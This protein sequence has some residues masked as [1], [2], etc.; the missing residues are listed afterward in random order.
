[1]ANLS[2]EERAR[3][4]DI[5]HNIQAASAS[6]ANVDPQKVPNIEEIE[7]CL[8][9]ADKTLRAVLQVSKQSKQ[10]GEQ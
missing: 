2:K 6:L 7:D 8:E 1:M 4:N 9:G 3:V 10:H 5:K